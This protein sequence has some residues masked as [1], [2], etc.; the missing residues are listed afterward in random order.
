MTEM[1]SHF[2]RQLLRT[3]CDRFTNRQPFG[4]IQDQSF[5]FAM[6]KGKVNSRSGR[7]VFTN[8]QHVVS[9]QTT[10]QHFLYG[11]EEPFDLCD[12]RELPFERFDARVLDRVA[13]RRRVP[14]FLNCF[15]VSMVEFGTRGNRDL[16]TGSRGNDLPD[17]LADF[18]LNG[19]TRY[20]LPPCR[21]CGIRGFLSG[22]V[23]LP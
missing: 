20:D 4:C 12:V 14:Q 21:A 9:G 23:L 7:L 13:A 8:S 15:I 18:I 5:D 3:E 11:R 19:N 6:S 16:L 2:E 17:K 22:R 1:Q 10:G